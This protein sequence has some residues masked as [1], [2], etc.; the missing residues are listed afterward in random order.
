MTVDRLSSDLPSIVA[1]GDLRGDRGDAPVIAGVAVR[2]CSRRGLLRT[3]LL[4]AAVGP[5]LGLTTGTR[6]DYGAAAPFSFAALIERARLLAAKPY[7]A[8]YQP[9]KEVTYRINYDVHGR[10]RFRTARAPNAEGPGMYPAT[11]FHLGRY[12]PKRVRMF[13]VAGGMARELLYSADM[14]DMP[15]DSPAR[16][17]PADAGYAGF[18]L[19]EARSR[20]DW[21]TQ[22]WLAFLGASYFRA[23][24]SDNQYG[25]SARGLAINTSAPGTAEEFPDFTEFYI[26]SPADPDGPVLIHALMES[27]SVAG[28]YRFACYRRTGVVMDVSARFFMR[29]AVA[30]LGVAP[31]T[32]M[33]WYAEYDKA[34]RA[35][36]RPEIHDSDGLSLMTGRGERLWRPLNNPRRV[37]TSSFSDDRPRGFGLLQRDRDFEHYLDGVNYQ[38]RPS[39]WVEP[40]GDWGP[41]AVQLVEIPTQDEYHDNVVA[42]WVPAAPALAGSEQRYD[43]RLHWQGA[44]PFPSALATVRATRVGQAPAYEEASI[45]PMRFVVEFAGGALNGLPSAAPVVA[46]I[47]ASRGTLVETRGEFIAQSRRFRAQF[48]LNAPGGQVVELRCF[49]LSGEQT[50]SE[51]W[52]HQYTPY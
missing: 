33:F 4:A 19:H 38:A 2:T 39:L 24:G 12:F 32:S 52:A 16:G 42:F 22:D 35:D 1:S 13:A 27:P 45:H 34:F 36:W 5:C 15:A 20:E 6:A 11:F 8:P 7:R 23:I 21:R 30:Q 46:R 43:Y 44:E 29:N 49:L 51:T 50:I 48:D 14:F 41:G 31:L 18:R 25:L 28:A 17:L 10:I 3:A 9:A 26:E 47:S 40:Q 37:V